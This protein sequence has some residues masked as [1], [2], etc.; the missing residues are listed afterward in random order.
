MRKPRKVPEPKFDR[1]TGFFV[2]VGFVTC[3]CVAVFVLVGLGMTIAKVWAGPS[4]SDCR[5][6][7]PNM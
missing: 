6:S 4:Y 2:F 1:A 7:F 3:M 5:A